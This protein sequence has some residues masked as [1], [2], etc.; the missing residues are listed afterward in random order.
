MRLI[1][2]MAAA[3]IAC[4]TWSIP[5]VSLAQSTPPLPTANQLLIQCEN[6][7]ADCYTY[8]LGVWDGMVEAGAIGNHQLMCSSGGVNAEQLRLAFNQI[9]AQYPALLS[10]PQGEFT[11]EVFIVTFGCPL[12]KT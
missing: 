4:S 6:R 11:A 9:A 8:L 5:V 3:A 1:G 2:T 12:P 10:E 7:S